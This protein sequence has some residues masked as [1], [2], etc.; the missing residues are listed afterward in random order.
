MGKGKGKRT[1][2]GVAEE[3]IGFNFVEG[4]FEEGFFAEF[5]V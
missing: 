1:E 5:V 3:L 2:K 4:G